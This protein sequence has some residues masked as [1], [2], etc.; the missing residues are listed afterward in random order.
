MESQSPV[1]MNQGGHHST[2]I[3][4]DDGKP[5]PVKPHGEHRPDEDQHRSYVPATI[6]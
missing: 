4:K 5:P 2:R 1:C 6:H 3:L